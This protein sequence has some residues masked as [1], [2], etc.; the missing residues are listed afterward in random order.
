MNRSLLFKF[1][2]L[3]DFIIYNPIEYKSKVDD[4]ELLFINMCHLL[5]GYRPHQAR[6]I[7]ISLIE[8]QVQQRKDTIVNL[9]ST[10]KQAEDL[11]DKSKKTLQDTT[12]INIDLNDINNS[13]TSNV[14]SNLV[15][16][17]PSTTVD[18]SSST[19][20]QTNFINKM[21][22]I[23]DSIEDVVE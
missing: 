15:E 20:P 14:A 3:I 18:S 13:N 10:L 5:N 4:I 1:L 7:V 8:H 6:Q 22:H 11:I 16:P 9:Q 23:L 17:S 19:S 21:L 12:T 2:E